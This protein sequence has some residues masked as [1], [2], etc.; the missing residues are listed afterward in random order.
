MLLWAEV[1]RYFFQTVLLFIWGI[2]SWVSLLDQMASLFL[3]FWGT[4]ILLFIAG[5][6]ILYSPTVHKCPK[7]SKS[8]PSLSDFCLFVFI[9]AILM[10]VR[11]CPTV[12]LSCLSLMMNDFERPFIGLLPVYISSWEKYSILCPFVSVLSLFLLLLSCSSLYFYTFHT[13]FSF[14]WVKK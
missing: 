13:F 12:A 8:L 10:G 2:Y 11:W 1:Y 4:T 3:I 9:V 7:F 6:Y 5:L 14:A